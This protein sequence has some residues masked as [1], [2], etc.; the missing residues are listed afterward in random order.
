MTRFRSF[1]LS[2]WLLVLLALLLTAE[3]VFAHIGW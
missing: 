2:T 1:D 3:L